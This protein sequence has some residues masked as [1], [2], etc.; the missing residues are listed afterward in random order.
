[1]REYMG[2]VNQEGAEG[3]SC[4]PARIF[5]CKIDSNRRAVQ[6]TVTVSKV[7]QTRRFLRAEPSGGNLS[8]QSS[9]LAACVGHGGQ[10]DDLTNLWAVWVL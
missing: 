7:D 1:M 3:W 5:M 9:V 10:C 4:A 8:L 2:W 6:C